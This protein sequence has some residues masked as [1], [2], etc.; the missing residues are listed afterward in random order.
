MTQNP[1]P[2]TGLISGLDGSQLVRLKQRRLLVEGR[3]CKEKHP[4]SPCQPPPPLQ[5]PQTL[6]KLMLGRRMG[7]NAAKP[8]EIFLLPSPLFDFVCAR[9]RFPGW[10][11]SARR[12]I[13]AVLTDS[14]DLIT[15][16]EAAKT[17]RSKETSWGGA[18]GGH[19]AKPSES[20]TSKFQFS[21]K[22]NI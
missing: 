12:Q 3:R 11:F 5:E 6:G 9:R 13:P 8:S 15:V 17:F 10:S 1:P 4:A 16:N 7:G 2:P 20:R 21:R 18:G 22:E 14:P 19:V